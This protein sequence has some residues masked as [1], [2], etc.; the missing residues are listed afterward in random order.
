MKIVQSFWTAGKDATNYNFGWLSPLDHYLSWI[1]SCNLLR[2]QYNHVSLV[3][4]Q[5]GYHIL[6]EELGLPYTEVDTCLDSLVEYKSHL[7]ALAKIKAYSIQREPFIHVDGD[8]FIWE[9]ID[10]PL[11][12]N[13]IIVQNRESIS[14][15]YRTMW[16]SIK[17]IIKDIP[18]L[19]RPFDQKRNGG[20]YNMGI[21]GGK[22]ISF[23]KEYC[24]ESFK[25]V[26]K[27]IIEMNR[28]EDININI[29]FEQVLLYEITKKKKKNVATYIKEDIG[30]NQYIN[31]GNFDEVPDRRKY[32]HLLGFYKQQQIV[33]LKLRAYVVKH[34]PEYYRKLEELL[35]LSPT[36]CEVNVKPDLQGISSC[37][38]D[39][40]LMLNQ[41]KLTIH[42]RYLLM[43]D[44][45]AL[46]SARILS[47]RLETNNNFKISRTIGIY[48]S[49]N[50]IEISCIDRT[51]VLETLTLDDV[52]F[53]IIDSSCDK[54]SFNQRAKDYLDKDFPEGE[55]L[56]YLE[57][58][59]RRI[60]MLTSIGVFVTSDIENVF[61]R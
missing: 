7:W 36:L 59:W 58:L 6:V 61:Y 28:L 35:H 55:I 8:V 3:T 47:E 15:Y 21:F 53:D 49:E 17:P 60:L 51:I 26:D 18:I 16:K 4:D 29:F 31:F 25:F 46:N 24:K 27:N 34:Y 20:A 57:T 33:S 2:K 22:D 41:N 10:I 45:V 43:R 52:I 23:I 30:D 42:P 56:N 32:L 12:G 37:E 9:P 13:D 19:L 38:H 48:K 1:L 11:E 50:S 14:D 40:L 5:Q 44:I 39:Y 54:M